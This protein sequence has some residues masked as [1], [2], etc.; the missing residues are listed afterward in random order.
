M[1]STR[2][3]FVAISIFFLCFVASG[4]GKGGYTEAER[5]DYLA[6]VGKILDG[7][8]FMVKDNSYGGPLDPEKQKA[9]KEM[10][11]VKSF[12]T[13][14]QDSALEERY[15]FIPLLDEL[16]AKAEG[17]IMLNAMAGPSADENF[18]GSGQLSAG[19]NKKMKKAETA[20]AEYKAE[21]EKVHKKYVE[22]GGAAAPSPSASATP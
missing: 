4:C 3:K 11:S 7:H 9:L 20:L 21:I 5:Q 8:T 10:V 6:G 18:D 16:S 17:Y 22:A 1:S 2:L 13:K 15:G 19:E 14:Y 12:K